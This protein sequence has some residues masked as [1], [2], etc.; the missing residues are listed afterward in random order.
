MFIITFR[1]K[2]LQYQALTGVCGSPMVAEA[3][4]ESTF[5]LNDVYM[6]TCRHH[7]TPLWRRRRLRCLEMEM[8]I[9]RK[10]FYRSADGHVPI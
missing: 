6:L 4:A 2:Y 8:E 3:E 9:R 7:S 1:R 10:E 5:E